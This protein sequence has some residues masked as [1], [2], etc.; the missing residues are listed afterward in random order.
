MI[1]SAEVVTEV[2][3]KEIENAIE[4]EIED[5]IDRGR[6]LMTIDDEVE[7]VVVAVEII[8]QDHQDPDVT[9]QEIVTTQEKQIHTKHDHRLI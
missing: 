2:I 3:G 1:M 4:T 8:V 7:V 6:D 9:I 5:E